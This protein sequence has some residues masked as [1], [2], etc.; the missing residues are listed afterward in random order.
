LYE[1]FRLA[2]EKEEK[3]G[4]TD[5]DV[6]VN[7]PQSIIA[8]HIDYMVKVAG[9]DCVA[10]GSDFD[11]IPAAPQGVTGS[12]FYPVLEAELRSRG[13]SEK[14]IEKIFNGNFL[15]VLETWG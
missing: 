8:D 1:P 11:G 15:R 3:N 4:D 9:E 6:S 12:D 13:Y 10:L 7:V 14:R 5:S 2:F